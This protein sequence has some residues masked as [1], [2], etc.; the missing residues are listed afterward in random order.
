MKSDPVFIC[1]RSLFM[2]ELASGY[3][4]RQEYNRLIFQLSMSFRSISKSQAM[5]D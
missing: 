2:I 1:E 4:E 3:K 5:T